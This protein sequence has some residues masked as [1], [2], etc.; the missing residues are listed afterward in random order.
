MNLKNNNYFIKGN[1]V[2]L[3]PFE[4]SDINKKY[5]SWMNNPLLN[6][7]IEARFPIS[8]IEAIKFYED[9][10]KT[11]DIII[12]AIC[13]NKT[14]NHL[15]N[16]MISNLDWINK[17][18]RYGRLIGENKKRGLGIGTEV[19]RLIQNYVFNKLNFNTL[20]CAVNVN[21]KAS[22]KSN[23]KSGMKIEGKSK[24]AMYF[25]GK[26]LDSINF[27]ITKKEFLKLK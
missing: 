2:Y 26:Y 10:K 15:G 3:R 13:N 17:R 23:I 27:G 20:Y 12:F 1:H 16:C 14:N 24:E 5:L 21:N 9:S 11:K 6:A 25:N 19:T 18:C 22:I 4:L 7:G 8:K